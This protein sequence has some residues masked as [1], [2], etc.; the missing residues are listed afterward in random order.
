MTHTWPQALAL[1]NAKTAAALRA[2]TRSVI[3]GKALLMVR[4]LKGGISCS[5]IFITGQVT[6]QSRH[7]S[8]SINFARI[9]LT[10]TVLRSARF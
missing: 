10:P 5:A 4:M 3:S 8:T 6:P 2:S 7:S 9:L 1:T